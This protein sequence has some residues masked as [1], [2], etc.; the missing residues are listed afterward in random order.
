MDDITT[1]LDEYSTLPLIQRGYRGRLIQSA[2]RE[3]A[4][5]L[6]ILRQ[7]F[8][9]FACHT[10]ECGGGD[11]ERCQCGFLDIWTKIN[12]VS[13]SLPPTESKK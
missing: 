3:G 12:A 1:R 9:E 13:S 5:E 8:L 2:M 4:S 11:G 6:R 7:N 10:P